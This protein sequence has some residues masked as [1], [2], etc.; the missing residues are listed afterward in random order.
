VGI[1]LGLTLFFPNFENFKNEGIGCVV[2]AHD[3][4]ELSGGF[5]VPRLKIKILSLE[6]RDG[7]FEKLL[8]SNMECK[9]KG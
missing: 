5:H 8:I 3:G 4:S 9:N 7:V 2:M 6:R 1:R